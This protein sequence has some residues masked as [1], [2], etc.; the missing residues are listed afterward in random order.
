MWVLNWLPAVA[1]H[2]MLIAG[3]LGLLAS[4]VLS[5]IPFI[6]VYRLPIQ[7]GA[8]FLVILSVWYE[9]GIVKDAEWK[10]RVAEL[11]ITLAKAEAKSEKVNTQI[12]TKVVTKIQVIKDTTNA[13]TKY[14][15][16]YVA[17]D[18][19]AECR[20][21]NASVM[22]HNSASQGEV[23]GSS[24]STIRGTSEVKASE[25]L[26]TVNENYGTYYQVVEK[27]KGWQEWYAAQKKI[28]EEIK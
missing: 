1:F 7:V 15:T 12:V 22:L 13:N 11:E 9:G 28:F 20:L 26:E 10:A 21:T 5:F 18:L 6:T 8:I 27:L 17:K 23:P 16:E 24:V 2:L 14:I 3:I 25:L 19:D 4:W